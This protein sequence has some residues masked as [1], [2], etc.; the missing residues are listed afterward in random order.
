MSLCSRTD[1]RCQT[2]PRRR[3]ELRLGVA[4]RP[5]G[6]GSR[7]AT[8]RTWDRRYGIGPR[9]TPPA[10]TAGTRRGRRCSACATHQARRPRTG[11]AAARRPVDPAASHRASGWAAHPRRARSTPGG[12]A[13]LAPPSP[14]GRAGRRRAPAAGRR[15]P[16]GRDALAGLAAD[17]DRPLGRRRPRTGA[18]PRGALSAAWPAAGRPGRPDVPVRCVLASG[19]RVELGTAHRGR[20][21]AAATAVAPG[22]P[23]GS[24]RRGLARAHRADGRA[25]RRWRPRSCRQLD[26]CRPSPCRPRPVTAP[27]RVLWAAAELDAAR[28]EPRRIRAAPAGVA[29]PTGRCRPVAD[30]CRPTRRRGTATIGAG[31]TCARRTPSVHDDAESRRRRRHCGDASRWTSSLPVACRPRGRRADGGVG[32]ASS[33]GACR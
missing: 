11:C 7:R 28:R 12:R 3:D 25:A 18:A 31:A 29:G 17:A 32:V 19:P 4:A 1:G 23:P 20:G 10:G 8:L 5:A 15:A 2:G 21:R 16:H 27:S 33:C 30:R 6:S 26:R 9:G 22:R 13:G 14:Y 24:L